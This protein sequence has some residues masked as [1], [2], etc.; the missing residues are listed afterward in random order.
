MKLA[1]KVPW[2]WY[3]NDVSINL[4]K[5]DILMTV[6]YLLDIFN[7]KHMQFDFSCV[8]KS[9]CFLLKIGH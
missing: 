7:L 9:V 5:E 2:R 3:L 1:L 4:V 6:S 8:F